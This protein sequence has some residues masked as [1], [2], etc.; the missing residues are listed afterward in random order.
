MLNGLTIFGIY[1][2]IN[3]INHPNKNKFLFFAHFLVSCL[4]FA[5]TLYFSHFFTLLPIHIFY[6]I[7]HLK[8]VS[9]SVRNLMNFKYLLFF[10]DVILLWIYQRN[11]VWQTRPLQGRRRLRRY[12]VLSLVVLMVWGG[13]QVLY[14]NVTGYYTPLNL[15]VF[16]YHIYDIANFVRGKVPAEEVETTWTDVLEEEESSQELAKYFGIAEGRNVIMVQAE[17]L[18][19]FVLNRQVDGQW[20]TPVFHHLLAK[21]HGVI[22]S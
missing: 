1:Y 18:Q 13:I 7:K 15:G 9:D 22:S 11:V 10:V 3:T 20:I 21:G 16:N 8:G 14:N 19:S 2:L 12:L 4:L 6:Q 17:S 5:N